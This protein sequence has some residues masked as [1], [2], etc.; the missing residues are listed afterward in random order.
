[1]DRGKSECATTAE[2]SAFRAED[3]AAVAVLGKIKNEETTKGN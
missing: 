3:I 1:M 2:Q